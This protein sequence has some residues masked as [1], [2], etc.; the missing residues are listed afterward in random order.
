MCKVIEKPETY[1]CAIL[2]VRKIINLLGGGRQIKTP[3]RKCYNQNSRTPDKFK[4][5][6]IIKP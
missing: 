2:L 1:V 5:R 6:Q 3:F 4:L